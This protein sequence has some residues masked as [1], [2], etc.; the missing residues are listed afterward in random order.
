MSIILKESDRLNKSIA[1]FLRFVKPQERIASEFDIAAS[2]SETLDLLSN[3][4]ELSASHLIEREIEPSSFSILGDPDQIRQV[5]WNIAKNAIQAMSAGGTLH[6]STDLDGDFYRIS[7]LDSGKG[8]SDDDQRKMF[9]PFRTNFPSGTGLGMAIS[10]RIIQ[11]H[12]GKIAVE[13]RE[14]QGTAITISLPLTARSSAQV[15]MEPETAEI[16]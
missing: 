1:D 15:I 10:Y 4:P 5:F 3:S 2:L 13:S 7:F 12:G 14:G 8:M 11:E 9:Q 6:V 16:S